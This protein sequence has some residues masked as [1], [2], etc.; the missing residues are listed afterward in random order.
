MAPLFVHRGFRDRF[1]EVPRW[2]EIINDAGRFMDA[3]AAKAGALGWTVHDVFGIDAK[4]PER[5]HDLAGLVPLMEGRPVV[6]VTADAATLRTR[7]GKA[8]RV[9]RRRGPTGA[10]LW[11]L[12]EG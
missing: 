10:L 1:I 11:Q 4:A 3:W 5:R 6:A 9:F 8:V 7:T 2:W 12:G